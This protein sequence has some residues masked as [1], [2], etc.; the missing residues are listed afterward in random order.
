MCNECESSARVG[1][2]PASASASAS[3]G[4]ST[5]TYLTGNSSYDLSINNSLFNNVNNLSLIHSLP[6]IRLFDG[7]MCQ[8]L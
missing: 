6:L 4:S 3:Q 8:Q 7:G 5:T 1:T 2:A